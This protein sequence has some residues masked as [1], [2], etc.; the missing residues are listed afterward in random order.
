MII[1][2]SFWIIVIIVGILFGCVILFV[3]CL[4]DKMGV[5]EGVDMGYEY[6]GIC[7]LNN[8]LLKWWIYLFIGIF[9]FVVIYLIFYLGLG[10]FKG[11]FGW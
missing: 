6:D 4:K 9:I 7:E 11:I 8:L 2:W 3:W 10:S 1:F 5:E